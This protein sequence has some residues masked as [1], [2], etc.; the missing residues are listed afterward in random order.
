[1][2]SR[3][4]FVLVLLFAL[5]SASLSC[6][7]SNNQREFDLDAFK[8]GLKE[9]N[10]IEVL[11]T[12]E[13]QVSKEVA[14][15]EPFLVRLPGIAT[16]GYI[17][18][19]PSTAP[20]HSQISV[21][22][23]KRTPDGIDFLGCISTQANREPG[24]YGGKNIE[25]WA[26]QVSPNATVDSLPRNVTLH[27]GRPWSEVVER[28]VHIIITPIAGNNVQTATVTTVTGNGESMSEATDVPV[29][30]ETASPNTNHDLNNNSSVDPLSAGALSNVTFPTDTSPY[31]SIPD[32]DPTLLE[33]NTPLQNEVDT[34]ELQEENDEDSDSDSDS[35]NDVYGDS[36]EV[37][38]HTTTTT[39]I[40]TTTLADDPLYDDSVRADTLEPDNRRAIDDDD[41][42]V[43]VVGIPIVSEDRNVDVDSAWYDREDRE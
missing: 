17:W 29:V 36:D 10:V 11:E 18:M 31:D 33:V 43:D 12:D 4:L 20:R 21:N 32:V 28:R 35:D 9:E 3:L 16:A 15:G 25:E 42:D 19:W 41:D 14:V 1:M 39:T 37:P 27:Y 30:P 23:L 5:F 2:S 13:N 6:P 26:F 8:S 40:T 22:S 7:R 34:N 24:L 38:T